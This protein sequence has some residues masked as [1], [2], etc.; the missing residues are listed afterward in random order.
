[1]FCEVK[2]RTSARWGG[3]AAAVTR[4]KQAQ[5]RTLATSWLIAAGSPAVDVRFDVIA[6]DGLTLAHHEAAF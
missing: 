6:I 2:A 1:V 3:A 5:V 4:A